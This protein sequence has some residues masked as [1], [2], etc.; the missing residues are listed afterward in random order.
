M[1]QHGSDSKAISDQLRKMIDAKPVGSLAEWQTIS[2]FYLK[3][4]LAKELIELL[5]TT[6]DNNPL[7]PWA[8]FAE[9]LSRVVQ[10]MRQDLAD[11]VI[12]GAKATQC[13]EIL[14][15]S[16][17]LDN[18]DPA[19]KRARLDRRKEIDQRIEEMRK[20]LFGQ[21]ETIRS[22][23]LDA[24]EE[25]ALI[26]LNKIFP[27]DSA[28]HELIES[29]RAKKAMKFLEEKSQRQG[30]DEKPEFEPTLEAEL[31]E[32][33]KLIHGALTEIL[34]QEN[35]PSWLA[36]DFALQN[37]WQD[38]PEWGLEFLSEANIDAQDPQF[39]S[40]IWL[41]CELLLKSRRFV[42]LLDELN[43]W[44]ASAANE[45]DQVIGILYLR[46]QALFGLGQSV[47]AIELMEMI[48][49]SQPDYRSA[50]SFL[51]TWRNLKK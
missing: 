10:P 5:M 15:R 39:Q 27:K 40:I 44:E 16:H 21:L 36:R 47:N 30:G 9:G 6:I 23:E 48:A 24:E 17:A 18:M 42:Q 25:Q 49:S 22:Q 33:A 12:S 45:P 20:D 19:V 26:R 41:R 28:V 34:N 38:S 7:F 31:T 14:S 32:Q 2:Q 37:F 35:H 51:N 29:F 50:S 11:A 4:G 13:L 46:A 1:L 8:H 43:R 3:A